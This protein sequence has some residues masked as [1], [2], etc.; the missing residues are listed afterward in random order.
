MKERRKE[1]RTLEEKMAAISHVEASGELKAAEQNAVH[2]AAKATDGRPSVLYFFADWCQPCKQMDGVIQ[3]LAKD[4][5]KL[6]FFRVSESGA[7]YQR[8]LP[9][10]LFLLEQSRSVFVCFS[11]ME[12]EKTRSSASFTLLILR[13][14]HL[15]YR[16]HVLLSYLFFLIRS[17]RKLYL[18]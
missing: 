6:S 9:V 15:L 10:L 4:Y 11:V 1:E 5:P 7:L 13:C 18:N 2:D 17:T 3:Q 16:A 14:L 8:F 12:K